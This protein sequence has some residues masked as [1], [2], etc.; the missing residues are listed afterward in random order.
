MARCIR[1][2]HVAEENGRNGADPRVDWF[3]KKADAELCQF[4]WLAEWRDIAEEGD[5]ITKMVTLAPVS[6]PVTR[7]ALALWLFA[8]SVRAN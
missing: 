2:W 6:V 4:A 8:F 1:L 7:E 3:A 5:D